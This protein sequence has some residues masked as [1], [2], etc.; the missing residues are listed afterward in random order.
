MRAVPYQSALA[1]ALLTFVALGFDT[2]LGSKAWP[3]SPEVTLALSLMYGTWLWL[4]SPSPLRQS[5][6]HMLWLSTLGELLFCKVLGMYTYR[7]HNIPWYVPVGHALV[8]A[9]G[10][11]L[12]QRAVHFPQCKRYATGAYLLLFLI[13]GSCGDVFSLCMG[14]IFT[15]AIWKSRN[16]ILYACIG[17]F[18][19]YIECVGTGWGCWAWEKQIWA[20]RSFNPPLGAVLFY[21]GGDFLLGK[22]IAIK[23]WKRL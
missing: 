16:G 13:L 11:H 3:S 23:N 20:M 8:Y 18:V 7:M 10:W 9:Q 17:I 14:S 2:D 6:W 22:I 4:H 12:A 15:W 19:L 21:A 1:F 5:M